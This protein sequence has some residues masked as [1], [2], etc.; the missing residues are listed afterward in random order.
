MCIRDRSSTAA[1]AGWLPTPKVDHPAPAARTAS[2]RSSVC[3]VGWHPWG[4]RPKSGRLGAECSGQPADHGL[5]QLG[6]TLDHH[7]WA[8]TADLGAERLGVGVVNGDERPGVVDL[9]DR[10]RLP[11]QT[12]PG[13][14]SYM[15]GSRAGVAIDGYVAD[16]RC[17]LMI[18]WH[19]VCPGLALD[20]DLTLDP[21]QP[22]YP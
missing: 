20:G 13:A 4:D 16:H 19:L 2:W 7:I 17:R 5:P 22:A 3:L 10:V 15:Q 9:L 21:A 8:E 18:L 1:T 6:G 12:M 14:H 11:A